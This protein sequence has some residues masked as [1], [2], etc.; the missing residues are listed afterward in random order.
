[1]KSLVRYAL[2]IL[3]LM[4]QYSS[5][6]DFDKE[7]DIPL[8][9][10]S[11]TYNKTTLNTTTQK[12]PEEQFAALE[13]KIKKQYPR[14]LGARIHAH[15]YDYFEKAAQE[16][17]AII[18]NNEV[19]KKFSL[20]A[21]SYYADAIEGLLKETELHYENVTC[22]THYPLLIIQTH[23]NHHHFLKNFLFPS[24]RIS[25]NLLIEKSIF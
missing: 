12:T 7:A 23:L 14:H 21:R 4:P 3:T 22:E 8:E 5:S 24:E 18:A 10:L 19:I 20:I 1:M 17:P 25:C 11:A 9:Q 13:E 2:A 16:A 15:M 6:M